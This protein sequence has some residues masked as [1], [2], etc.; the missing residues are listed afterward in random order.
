M[1]D[2]K[3]VLATIIRLIIFCQLTC[4]LTL[5]FSFTRSQILLMT[6]GKEET[7]SMCSNIIMNVLI[8]IAPI[9][10]AIWYP[11][12]GTI[13]AV[14]GA[15]AGLHTIYLIPTLTYIA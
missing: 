11:K 8:M 6:T 4:S 9:A 1:F 10:T 13:A 2:A 14:T 15:V 7:E 5:I 12:V 3:N